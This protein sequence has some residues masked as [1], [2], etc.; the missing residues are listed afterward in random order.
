MGKLDRKGAHPLYCS[1]IPLK[2]SRLRVA[3]ETLLPVS[4][5]A[6]LYTRIRIIVPLATVL[7]S[8]HCCWAIYHQKA[9][10]TSG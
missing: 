8:L 2:Y 4:L 1:G 5:T 3:A 6:I 7:D 10:S 9:S